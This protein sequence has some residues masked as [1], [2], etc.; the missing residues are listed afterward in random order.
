MFQDTTSFEPTADLPMGGA[1][2][3]AT[4]EVGQF[5]QVHRDDVARLLYSVFSRAP[6]GTYILGRSF[7]ES[8]SG[9]PTIFP[10]LVLGADG[11]FELLVDA[12][13]KD[14]ET[15]ALRREAY[16]PPHATFHG[17]TSAAFDNLAA[18]LVL[19]V[20]FD[21]PLDA[22]AKLS[23]L[24]AILGPSTLVSTS[25]GS[26]FDAA[27]VEYHK[28]RAIWRLAAPTQDV[29]EHELLREAGE[30]AALYAGTDK[31][32]ASPVHPHRVPGTW[33]Q[34]GS[35]RLSRVITYRPDA[36]IDLT[37][38]HEKLKAA[39]EAVLGPSGARVKRD[40]TALSPE[41]PIEKLR[42]AMA[43]VPN[44]IG[45]NWEEF[46][47]IGLALYR[48]SG[49]SQE[50]LEE[51]LAW[52]RKSE[53]HDEDVSLERW[54]H[55]A[56]SPPSRTGF[57]KIARLARKAGWIEGDLTGIVMVPQSPPPP[58]LVAG[59]AN[60]LQLKATYYIPRDG[61]QRPLPVLAATVGIFRN[62][63]EFENLFAYNEF[64]RAP[65]IWPQRIRVDDN[66]ISRTQEALQLRHKLERI[67]FA[68]VKQAI[69]LRALE[70]RY[71]PVRDYFTTCERNYDGAPRLATLL[72]KY[73]GTAQDDYHAR[74][75]TWWIIQIVARIFVPGCQA[76]Y[77]LM[78][79]GEQGWGKSSLAGIL[80]G[81]WFS[82][83]LPDIRNKDASQHLA[84][85]LIIELPELSALSRASVEA[86]KSFATRRVEM[87]RRPYDSMESEEPRQNTFVATT[88][89]STPLR[90]TTGNRRFWPVAIG[91]LDLAGLKRDRDQIF[92]EAIVLY[93]AGHPW[94]P[95][96]EFERTIITPH[97]ESRLETDAWEAPILDVLNEIAQ[98]PRSGSPP[99]PR[100][101]ITLVDLAHRALSLP[102]DRLDRSASQRII[103]ALRRAGWKDARSN[104]GRFWELPSGWTEPAPLPPALAVVATPPPPPPMASVAAVAT[105]GAE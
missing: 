6:A 33:H 1:S 87:Y 70:N 64:A 80:G 18:G 21:K 42:R 47:R 53:F 25:G 5:P 35:P 4:V 34:K 96:R 36:E 88:N 9:A 69:L 67:S 60:G 95:E 56:K 22:A 99:Y 74:I 40:Y 86:V 93:K 39:V 15:A 32:A 28:L 57:G 13:A 77:I 63:R 105:E 84:G 92:G 61:K 3:T 90:D 89:Q 45:R 51:F 14:A 54:S 100:P 48:A 79:L 30:L 50:G 11:D 65:E 43:H 37:E 78:M 2:A 91:T 41:V 101:R 94:W 62:E 75:G 17:A 27:G 46:N 83:A 55:Y 97:Q 72:H 102:K 81:E 10:A 59:L 85:R 44:D 38:A 19:V 26:D 98:R 16:A 31:S 68:T 103:T 52:S 29:D 71:H 23:S 76:D 58:P 12:I 82:D 104:A 8:G 7:P 49:G 24:E 20:D 73:L 66:A